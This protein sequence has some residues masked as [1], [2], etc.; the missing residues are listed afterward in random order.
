MEKSKTFQISQSNEE[1][2]GEPSDEEIQEL[3]K[4]RLPQVRSFDGRKLSF[5]DGFWV[6][7]SYTGS[8]IS[9][10]SHFK[11]HNTDLILASSLKSGTTWL[12]ALTFSIVN[13][14]KYSLFESPLLTAN[15]HELVP[16]LEINLYGK[17]K[18]LNLDDIPCPRLFSTHVPFSAL[19]QPIV[20][21]KCRILYICRNP[22]DQ[23]I[24]YWHF[25]LKIQHDEHDTERPPSIDEAFEEFCRG[26]HNYGPFWD[27]EM[28]YWKASI[29]SPDKVLFLKYEDLKEDINYCIKKIAEFLGF[30]FSRE[31]EKLGLVE[32]IS[33]MCSLQNLKNL[34]VNKEGRWFPSIPNSSF[35]R[36]GKVGDWANFLSASQ[37]ERLEKITKDK[38]SGSGLTLKYFF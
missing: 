15:P 38:L 24:S 17:A 37:A 11:A 13:R 18:N 28:G 8:I 12:K 26:F 4:T 25:K 35:F 31:E 36:N 19:P 21:S 3:S 7:S 30:P 6:I 10:Q 16:N 33:S 2:P 34:R 14:T 23:F 1:T 27:H 29:E 20:N 5:Y 22:V 9:F 32:Q